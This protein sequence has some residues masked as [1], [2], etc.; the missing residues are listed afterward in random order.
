MLLIRQKSRLVQFGLFSFFLPFGV[1]HCHQR[2]KYEIRISKSEAD[3]EFKC[4]ISKTEQD[5]LTDMKH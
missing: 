5:L 2:C 1:I 4:Q 3:S